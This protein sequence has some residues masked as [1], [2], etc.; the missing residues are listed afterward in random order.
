MSLGQKKRPYNKI[1]KGQRAPSFFVRR[2]SC[3]CR[4]F[5]TDKCYIGRFVNRPY[6]VIG[7]GFCVRDVPRHYISSAGV[8]VIVLSKSMVL[9]VYSP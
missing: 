5:I 8:W 4:C 9:P 1:Q 2:T 3:S 6:G 7:R